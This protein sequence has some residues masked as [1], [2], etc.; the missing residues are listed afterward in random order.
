M[1]I[2]S[3]VCYKINLSWYP[4]SSELASYT[5]EHW[6]FIALSVPKIVDIDQYLLKLFENITG[7]VYRFLEPQC[8]M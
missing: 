3:T 7:F 4:V 6:K 8:I 5:C 2:V 1:Q